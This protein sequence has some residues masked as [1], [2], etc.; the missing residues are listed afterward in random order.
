MA[1]PGV[2]K[3]RKPEE[4]SPSNKNKKAKQISEKCVTCSKD[5]KQDAIECF[6]CRKWE[7]RVCANISINE[8]NMLSNSS[9]KIMFFCTLCFSK[10]PFALRIESEAT[11]KSQESE[12]LKSRMEAV[13]EKLTEVLK[14]FKV[15]VQQKVNSEENSDD[16]YAHIATSIVTEQK[17]KERRQL[18]LILHN[19][20]ESEE[21]E[22]SN[23]KKDDITGAASL[24]SEYLGV[25]CAI[26]NA[27]RIGKKGIKPRLLKV[28]VSNLQDKI[29]ILRGKMKLKNEGNPEHIKSVF[30]TADYTPLEQKRN[31]ILR[32]KL[33]D[34][35]KDGNNYYIKNG[36]IVPR[37]P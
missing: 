23:R 11:A 37:R 15:P 10:V 4:T 31:K 2:S 18:N 27:I 34:M 9:K 12:N 29:T 6:W 19:V 26:T 35:N 17:E 3:R 21:E 8:Y 25:D 22:P 7:H 1:T 14:E 24:F 28:S 5:V 13:E 32:E 36:K 30:I 20:K 33:N 16:S